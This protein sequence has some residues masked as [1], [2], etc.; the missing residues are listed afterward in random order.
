M[1]V[2]GRAMF[3]SDFPLVRMTLV[4]GE[5]YTQY[6]NYHLPFVGLPAVSLAQNYTYIGLAG[7]RFRFTKSQYASF[8]FNTMWQDS[9]LLLTNKL[10]TTYGI[11]FRY[12]IKSF[13]GPLEVTIG[14]SGSTEKPT[15]SANFGY[16]F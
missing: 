12:S 2:Y 15:F 11:G 13:L 9:K 10:E 1:E 8:L 6:F 3:K 5:P 4:G 16:W 7:L 14:Y